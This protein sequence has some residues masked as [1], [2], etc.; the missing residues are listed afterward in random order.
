MIRITMICV[1]I[2]LFFSSGVHGVVYE[3]E[4]SE[5]AGMAADTTITTTF[6][7]NGP[8][9]TVN[10][11]SARVTGSITYLGLIECI[12]TPPDT[13]TRPID[14]G[15]FITKAGTPGYWSGSPGFLSQV[16]PFYETYIHHT[17][18]NGFS[19]VADGDTIQVEFYF[20]PA[21]LIGICHPITEP[22]TG[23]IS[24]A[25]ILID[26]LATIPAE[27]S[28]WGRIKNLY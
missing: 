2:C 6:I 22:S 24:S 15:T 28:T 18:S 13:S 12:S 11:L 19:T 20:Y 4:L 3:F 25:Y 9:G 27:K 14:I 5:L 16:G 1:I 26:V 17:Y 23:I 7:Y 21:I 10:A 8:S